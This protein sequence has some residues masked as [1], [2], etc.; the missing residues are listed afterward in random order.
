[1]PQMRNRYVTMAF[2][3]MIVG[4]VV[5]IIE[6][7]VLPDLLNVIEH[8]AYAVGGVMGTLALLEFKRTGAGGA[9]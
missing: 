7:F 4:Y 9:R 3:A 1:M 2:L 6:G 8:I 5:T